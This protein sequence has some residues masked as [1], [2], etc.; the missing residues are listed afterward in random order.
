[1]SSAAPEKD[2][3]PA[4]SSL[5]EQAR[6]RVRAKHLSRRTEQAYTHWTTALGTLPP[7]S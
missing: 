3:I 2:R 5:L 7:L 1:M 4:P 6:R